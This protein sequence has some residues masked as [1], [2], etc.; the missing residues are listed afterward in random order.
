MASTAFGRLNRRADPYADDTAGRSPW[1]RPGFIASGAV[2][3]GLLITALVLL[4]LPPAEPGGTTAA[5]AP[6]PSAP[7]PQPSQ[8][9]ADG[10]DEQAPVAGESV[11]GLEPG[12]QAIPTT[13]PDAQWQLVG[14]TAVPID[15]D[16]A[17]PGTTTDDGF[18]SCFSHDPTGAL[19]AG[20]NWWAQTLNG[21]A[22]QVYEEL[23]AATPE[24]D[25][26]LEQGLDEST[27][28]VGQI[29]GYRF[30]DVDD[31]RVII[32]L[33]FR[34]PTGQFFSVSTPMRWEEGDWKL[35]VPSTGDASVGALPD[36]TGFTPWSGVG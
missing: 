33:A 21:R 8:P 23:T 34:A 1:R 32:E 18:A 12:A 26:A 25:A 29:A 28:G 27:D 10:V 22:V 7:A 4:V 9:P 15:P 30:V 3:A 11:C 17:G 20:I 35:V 5:P 31:D 24:R 14:T 13:A 19:F 2:L 6:S 36:L 16:G